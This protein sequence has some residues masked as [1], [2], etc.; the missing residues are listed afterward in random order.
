MGRGVTPQD[1]AA[2]RPLA[3]PLPLL[4]ALALALTPTLNPNP[5]LT[6]TLN[7][8]IPLTTTHNQEGATPLQ[9]PGGR[10]VRDVRVRARAR[11]RARARV[12]VRVR[13]RVR[14][15]LAHLSR[16]LR[17]V[18]R[19]TMSAAELTPTNS[20]VSLRALDQSRRMF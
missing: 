1:A 5:T 19:E 18:R 20:A 7:S 14:A 10:L 16:L 2:P 6:R 8:T 4:L 9:P 17:K 15:G 11:A 12:R 13:V 3:L